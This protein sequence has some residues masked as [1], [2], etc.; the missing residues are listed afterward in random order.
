MRDV[1]ADMFKSLADPVF[2]YVFIYLFGVYLPALP[3]TQTISR[4]IIGWLVNKKLER[5]Q[6]EEGVV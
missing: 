5:V 1:V 2:M 3:G 4:R 6:K